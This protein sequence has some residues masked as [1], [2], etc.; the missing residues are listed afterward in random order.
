[1]HI[2]RSLLLIATCATPS[3]A[4]Q[5]PARWTV[6]TAMELR[7]LSEPRVSPDGSRVAYVVGENVMTDEKS[8]V[9]RHLWLART[10]GTEAMQ[11]TFGDQSS[12][13]P[14]WLPDGSGIVFA[15]KRS[16]KNHLYLLRLRGGEAEPL[17]SS[18]TKLDVNGFAISPD[19]RSVAFTASESRED[20]EKRKKGKEDFFWVDE[21]DRPRRLYVLPLSG[22]PGRSR[23]HRKLVSGAFDVADIDWSADGKWIAF[24]RTRSTVANDWPTGDVVLVDVSAGT[25]RDLAATPAAES[26]PRFSPD[27]QWVAM[28]VSDIPVRWAGS[29]RVQ[30]VHVTTGERRDLAS[31]YDVQPDILGFSRDG[32][33][34]YVAET[35]GTVDRIYAI[36]VAANRVVDVDAG[37]Q[38]MGSGRLNTTG[39]WLAWVGQSSRTPPE[40]F[41]SRVDR[42]APVQVSSAN[43]FATR[44]AIPT[45][46]VVRW[47]S[48]DGTEIEGLLTYPIAYRA[49]TR[50]PLALV[51]H[52]GPAGVFK[53]TFVATPGAFSAVLLAQNGFAVLRPNPRGS[54]GYGVTFR[55]ANVKDWGGGDY[56]DLMTG[57]DAMIDRGVADPERMAVMGW[58]YG[59]FMTSWVITHTNRFKAAIAGAAVTNL[60]SFTGTADIPGFIPDYFGGQYWEAFDLWREHSPIMHVQNATTPTLIIH[61]DADDRVPISQGYELYNALQLRGIPSR[62]LVLPRQPHGPTEPKMRRAMMTATLEWLASYV[63]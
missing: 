6:D 50:V 43:V 5:E 62:M 59:G 61:G 35:R 53:Q 2:L 54:S 45:T 32:K 12:G 24:T 27:G 58:S 18:T 16:G 8:E 9:L 48:T 20:E 47:K 26:S 21:K 29:S 22:E 42:F 17:M 63:K 57:V 55:R 25:T 38:V 10:D 33:R 52:G 28:Q 15:S 40:V 1:M 44:L 49:G 4:A 14:A 30:L 7:T 56:Q 37:T 51:I 36:D 41:V 60:F 11:V 19:G 34:I 3:L 46:E 13:S 23:E 31:T 39:T